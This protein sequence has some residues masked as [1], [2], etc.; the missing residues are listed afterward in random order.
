LT[1][2]KARIVGLFLVLLPLIYLVLWNAVT[3]VPGGGSAYTPMQWSGIII[4]EVVVIVGIGLALKGEGR[5][6]IAGVLVAGIPAV[7]L[8][9]SQFLFVSL[10]NWQSLSVVDK[11]E[12]VD[13]FGVIALGFILQLANLGSKS[14]SMVRRDGEGALPSAGHADKAES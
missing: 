11:G 7:V 1:A 4:G 2:T 14:S 3:Y 9:T 12:L 6:R 8:G 13:V 10:P 5:L